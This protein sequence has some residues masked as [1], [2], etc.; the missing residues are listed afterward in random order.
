MAR[1]FLWQKRP[2]NISLLIKLSSLSVY[3]LL[4]LL[5]LYSLGERGIFCKARSTWVMRVV[6]ARPHRGR[7]LCAWKE[8]DNKIRMLSKET[9][10]MAKE[11]CNITVWTRSVRMERIFYGKNIL[12]QKRPVNIALW[13]RSVRVERGK[14][15]KQIRN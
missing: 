13:T 4:L 3:L 5:L 6:W 1:I 12:W 9:Y 8:T 14:M 10:F 11:A 7:D 2:V 15:R